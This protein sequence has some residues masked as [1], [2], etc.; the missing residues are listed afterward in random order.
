MRQALRP[1]QTFGPTSG[2]EFNP[3]R[4]AG[5]RIALFPPPKPLNGCLGK[6]S[7]KGKKLLTPTRV[8]SIVRSHTVTTHTTHMRTKAL[9]IAV[10]LSAAGAATSMAQVYSVNAVG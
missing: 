6:R 5:W 8:L 1:S 3:A 7:K 10:A 9:I 4:P 2:T